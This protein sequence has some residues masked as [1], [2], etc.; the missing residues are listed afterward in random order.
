MGSAIISRIQPARISLPRGT[1]PDDPRHSLSIS[2]PASDPFQEDAF[3]CGRTPLP[4]VE[5]IHS[6]LLLRILAQVERLSREKGGREGDREKAEAEAPPLPGRIVLLSSPR[7]GYG[8]THFSERLRLLAE[9]AAD[10]LDLRFHPSRR[11]SWP[12]VL[13]T[14]LRQFSKSS[15]Q[16]AAEDSLLGKTA[17]HFL[18]ETVRAALAE[19]QGTPVPEMLRSPESSSG[20]AA[21]SEVHF[22]AGREPS[23]L[24]WALPRCGDLAGAAAVRIGSRFRLGE[25]GMRFWV[26]LLLDV[27][28]E[29]PGATH[30]LLGLSPGEARQRALQLLGIAVARRPLLLRIDHLDGFHRS[31]H[32][33]MELADLLVSIRSE[34][35]H[36]LSLLCLN[37]DVW[38]SAFRNQLPSAWLD[39][40]TSDLSELPSL[41]PE[42]AEELVRD[43]LHQH[44]IEAEQTG[45][46]AARLRRERDWDDPERAPLHP[47]GVLRDARALWEN[48]TEDPSLLENGRGIGVA[49]ALT[50][51]PAL[52]EDSEG[53]FSGKNAPE[54]AGTGPAAPGPRIA[55]KTPPSP[56]S[57]PFS[58][59]PALSPS[60]FSSAPQ[61]GAAGDP[62]AAEFSRG[63]STGESGTDE[64]PLAPS[65]ELSEILEL[66]EDIRKNGD[67]ILSEVGTSG[68]TPAPVPTGSAT[69]LRAS[70]ARGKSSAAAESEPETEPVPEGGGDMPSSAAE[71]APSFPTGAPTSLP[72][73]FETLEAGS[74]TVRNLTSRSPSSESGDAS[75]L[76]AEEE[77][78]S[79][80]Q[81]EAES[82]SPASAAPGPAPE[83]PA[84]PKA[85]STKV[86]LPPEQPSLPVKPATPAPL[87][88]SA[89]P[90]GGDAPEPFQREAALE[91]LRQ[92]EQAL[93]S[94]AASTPWS[95]SELE[96]FLGDIAAE[97]PELHQ[98]ARNVTAQ[99]GRCYEWTVGGREVLLAFA[100]PD[101]VYFWSTLL[102]ELLA[103]PSGG[104][105][106]IAAF[107]LPGSSFDD[108]D[109]GGF[110]FAASS[111]QQLVDIVPLSSEEVALLQAADAFLQEADE[112]GQRHP[113]LRLL[114][115]RFA[116]L[117]RRL[118]W[119]LEIAS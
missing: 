38:E 4:G 50:G 44:G 74:L 20:F 47:R 58:M 87:S 72:E 92:R 70:T 81:A 32:V 79:A 91:K 94:G 118:C 43:R 78:G 90:A 19:G 85:E 101:D 103:V 24:E 77:E 62:V 84:P 33:A 49:S 25:G 6:S 86:P 116:T 45:N 65:G 51:S 115:E 54:S 109:L 41:S 66:I 97:H 17:R 104:I 23:L 82:E 18:S 8:K 39:R 11:I 1:M 61:A 14:L 48:T 71:D 93:L 114:V 117:W 34:V 102:R 89:P 29:V 113:A 67:S 73:N 56:E 119:P 3:V 60:G 46:F 22:V 63:I 53:E 106:K 80:S 5:R 15:R 57:T 105:E 21:P 111:V 40:L 99:G 83:T 98:S 107:S 76:V 13:G 10:C 52:D 59:S 27:C 75:G 108:S 100:G 96:R 2:G 31:D 69:G 55:G 37:D 110:G 88:L 30:S 64:D 68:E 28:R 12:A 26:R 112:Q 42:E 7:A 36:C 35:P 95:R 16:A 9:P